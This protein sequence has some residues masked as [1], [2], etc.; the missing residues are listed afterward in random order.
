MLGVQRESQHRAAHDEQAQSRPVLNVGSPICPTVVRDSLPRIQSFRARCG[1]R[2]RSVRGRA[3]AAD[4]AVAAVD[5]QR[6]VEQ[7]ADDSRLG[8]PSTRVART[9]SRHHVDT[10]CARVPHRDG[11]WRGPARRQFCAAIVKV[12]RHLVTGAGRHR[13][14]LSGIFRCGFGSRCERRRKLSCRRHSSS[15]SKIQRGGLRP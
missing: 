1:H 7:L 11:G 9:A 13:T 5:G 3:V 12:G 10:E 14:G 4:G 6:C 8:G 15:D 2:L